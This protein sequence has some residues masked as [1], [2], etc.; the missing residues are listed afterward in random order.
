MIR[1][2]S[3]MQR[4]ITSWSINREDSQGINFYFS[5]EKNQ[6]LFSFRQQS[7]LKYLKLNFVPQSKIF[8]CWRYGTIPNAEVVYQEREKIGAAMN[9]FHRCFITYRFFSNRPSYYI[10]ISC[11]ALTQKIKENIFLLDRCWGEFSS[12]ESMFPLQ[13]WWTSIFRWKW[14]ILV[15]ALFLTRCV[16]SAV[17]KQM[18]DTVQ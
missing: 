5:L 4:E 6:Y 11:P 10:Y 16:V 17:E 2:L 1:N 9:T 13:K 14:K 8:I 18:I 3:T 7:K 12:P 15:I